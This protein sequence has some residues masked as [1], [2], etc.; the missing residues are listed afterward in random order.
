MTRYY[1]LA[2]FLGL[3]AAP[4]WAVDTVVDVPQESSF[5]ATLTFTS[6]NGTAITPQT[7]TYA[8]HRKGSSAATYGPVVVPSPSATTNIDVPSIATTNVGSGTAEK[9]PFLFTWQWPI[10]DGRYGTKSVEFQVIRQP[11][12]GQVVR[13]PTPVR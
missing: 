6:E 9:V 5:R 8:V 3:L 2:L 11:Y 4:A 13:T 10:A 1:R 12:V 7:I